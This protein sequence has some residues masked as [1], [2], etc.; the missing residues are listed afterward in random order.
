MGGMRRA[1]VLVV[2]VCAAWGQETDAEARFLR[3]WYSLEDPAGVGAAEKIFS[4]MKGDRELLARCQIALAR[5]ERIRGKPHLARARLERL[6]RE[7]TDLP[8]IRGQAL[9]TLGFGVY[10]SG[11]RVLERGTFLDLDS[12]GLFKTE[13]PFPGGAAEMEHSRILPE[14]EEDGAFRDAAP[15]MSK[16]PWM[17]VRTNEDNTAWVQILQE[18][19]VAVVHFIT[20]LGGA[21]DALPAVRS[22]FC[23][24]HGALIKVHFQTHPA[25]ERYRIERRDGAGGF[26]ELSV[27]RQ[28]PFN[29]RDVDDGVR[30]GYRITGIT[31][32]GVAG[33]SVVS[34]STTGSRGVRHGT[35]VL[36]QRRNR[37]FDLLLGEVSDTSWDIELAGHWQHS[38]AFRNYLGQSIYPAPEDGEASSAWD[39]DQAASAQLP[40]GRYFLVPLRGG[41]VARCRVRLDQA[42]LTIEYEV[43]GDAAVLPPP[44]RIELTE[45][46]SGVA[47]KVVVPEP[48]FA[49]SVEAYNLTAGT[50]PDQLQLDDQGRAFDDKARKD[51]VRRYVVRAV[52]SRGRRTLRGEAR[53]ILH[54][55]EPRA[56][57]FQFHYQQGFSIEQ[58]RMTHAGEADV[59]F[60]ACAGGTAHITLTAGEGILS[61]GKTLP[62]KRDI[63][64][65]L[66]IFDMI[67]G[68][69]ADSIDLKGQAHGKKDDPS[70]DVFVIRT[71]GGGWAKLVIAARETV[72]VW[73][74][75]RATIRYVY[76]PREPVFVEAAAD[77]TAVRAGIRFAGIER[78]EII[79]RWQADHA[80]LSR[81]AAFK[82]RITRT[83]TA[84]G[85]V[86]D[87][88][89]SEEVLFDH[90]VTTDGRRA[91]FDLRTGKR[92]WQTWN[93]KFSGGAFHTRHSITDLGRLEWKDL[94]DRRSL[95]TW[96]QKSE[97][98]R[99]GHVY[100]VELGPEEQVLV[101]VT[102]Y[103]PPDRVVFERLVPDP[104]STKKIEA[105]A[106]RLCA[107]LP[108]TEEERA[109]AFEGGS[110]AYRV[111][112]LLRTLRFTIGVRD[113]DPV[114]RM[115]DLSLATGIA[116]K[117]DG[118][119]ARVSLLAGNQTLEGTL[120]DL[121]DLAGLRWRVDA[122]GVVRLR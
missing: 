49:A 77:E 78:F 13:R 95:E 52:D 8:A 73:S 93:L 90:V 89:D 101:R 36:D 2:L 63:A 82:E 45:R 19:P 116:F 40:A 87:P 67:T 66:E 64:T 112:G 122:R 96:P 72:G 31:R 85:T 86:P 29:D 17:R 59:F 42:A 118:A 9:R 94:L 56:G 16:K 60:S 108:R 7:V 88:A 55:S 74:K 69:D 58:Q 113:Q 27:I 10:F 26:R 83:L 62:W 76:N 91:M 120:Q 38:A 44:P 5:C 84:G 3:A 110:Q 47:V 117:V 65:S 46:E 54:P 24:G 28:P 98:V 50:A 61:V 99:Y 23:I 21:G 30:Y 80:R 41:G 22:P 15:P 97:K 102:G 11:I 57:T 51:Q 37:R 6:L 4:E 20:R 75:Q 35:C 18:Q 68:A 104:A 71:R 25:Y 107:D 12:G 121:E 106:G 81:D 119:P 105:H 109:R 48:F 92:T 34:Q 103:R 1:A 100:L 111:R 39:V 43:Y 70:T 14:S 114:E 32:D 79:A 115:K 33:V 53:I